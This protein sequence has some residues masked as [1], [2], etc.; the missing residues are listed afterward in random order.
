MRQMLLAGATALLLP[1]AAVSERV[2]ALGGSV[3]EIVYALGQQDRL[4]GRDTTSTYPPE[5]TALPD[6]GYI[7]ALSPEGVLSVEPEL[8]IAEGGAGP[9]EA[10]EILRAAS[11]PIVEVPEG[12]T[13][14]A[15]QAK[16]AAVAEALGVADEGVAL[17]AKV[18]AEL[19]EA[20]ALA[21]ENDPKRVLFVLSLA[22]GR[23]M[24][25]GEHSSAA[26]IIEMAGG[27]NALDG[28]EGYS[29]VTDEAVAA[30]APDVILMMTGGGD[31]TLTDEAVLSN[32]AIAA[33]PAG[34]N[35]RLIRMDGLLLLG[36][37]PR[38]GE[39]VGM[40]ARAL[41]AEG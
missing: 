16:I 22:G 8:I 31:H 18:G 41:A 4:V 9:A 37:G 7:R 34:E 36:F 1:T 33:T 21:A 29:Q 32:P 20:T 13:G 17:S 35:A 27:V 15:V 10:M 14:E 25:A 26:A 40:L 39:A 23:V 28:I 19:A 2:L 30:A 11:I 5:V 38:I 3:A 24:A 6:V 12:Y